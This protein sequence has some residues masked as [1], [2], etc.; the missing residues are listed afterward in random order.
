MPLILSLHSLIG[1]D[2]ASTIYGIGKKKP[3]KT[4]R[5]GIAPPM[6]GS[7]EKDMSTLVIKATQFIASCYG[8]AQFYEA[9]SDLRFKIWKSKTGRSSSKSFKLSS[10][11]PTSEAVDLHVRRAH[12]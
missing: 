9:M 12:H 1:C 10:L 7:Q 3:L 6:L 8:I 2:T 11:S 4:L 5:E